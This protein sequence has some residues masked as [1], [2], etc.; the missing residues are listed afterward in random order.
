MQHE[1]RNVRDFRSFVKRQI[2][3]KS[4]LSHEV[5]MKKLK[6]AKDEKGCKGCRALVFPSFLRTPLE[7]LP[8]Q[9]LHFSRN[10]SDFAAQ[11]ISSLFP[12]KNTCKPNPKCQKVI[13]HRDKLINSKI[14]Y[15]M[16]SSFHKL[17]ICRYT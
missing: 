15:E 12:K 6:N 16:F 4:T 11:S 9:K 2:L 13:D 10:D 8:R 1:P 7:H 14:T 3:E 5:F 17:D